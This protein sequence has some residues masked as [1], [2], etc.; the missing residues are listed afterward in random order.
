V[1]RRNSLPFGDRTSKIDGG[2]SM[3]TSCTVLL[4]LEFFRI[5]H[6]D[7]NNINDIHCS[8]IP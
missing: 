5:V 4:W 8:K 3:V 2:V 6:E 7:D 1:G